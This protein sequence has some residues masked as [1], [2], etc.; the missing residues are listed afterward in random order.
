[1]KKGIVEMADLVVVNKADGD[2]LPVARHTKVDYMHALQLQARQPDEWKPTV[3]RQLTF[4]CMLLWKTG[5]VVRYCLCTM[6]LPE[7]STLACGAQARMR[8]S[9]LLRVVAGSPLLECGC[10]EDQA[11]AKG[12]CCTLRRVFNWNSRF[13]DKVP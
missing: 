5:F 3:R 7:T 12:K 9:H 4:G 13:N 6:D 8:S 2:L 10:G 1:M 11:V